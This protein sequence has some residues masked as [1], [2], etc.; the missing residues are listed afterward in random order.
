MRVPRDH[1]REQSRR[2]LIDWAG[3]MVTAA[4]PNATTLFSAGFSAGFLVRRDESSDAVAATIVNR[5]HTCTAQRGV[6]AG[7]DAEASRRRSGLKG[8]DS[9]LE[10]LIDG[11]TRCPHNRTRGRNRTKDAPVTETPLDAA[12]KEPKDPLTS[13][14]AR[15]VL[16]S[17]S[18][19]GLLTT[20]AHMNGHTA[21]SDAI[22]LYCPC[23]G[24]PGRLT[25]CANNCSYAPDPPLCPDIFPRSSMM[26]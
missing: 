23:R 2:T 5:E 8:L 1:A 20:N 22:G 14:A 15:G 19:A 18:H 13:A 6:T 7:T 26:R 10:P 25:P 16:S 3:S 12:A 4:W 17:P 24:D 9:V 21:P 11:H